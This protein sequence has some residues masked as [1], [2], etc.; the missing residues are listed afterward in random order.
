LCEAMQVPKQAD[1]PLAAIS[2]LGEDMAREAYGYWLL[3]HPVHFVLQR[4]YFSMGPRLSLSE[5]ESHALM[6]VLNQ[7]FADDGLTFLA[8]STPD[9]WYLHV[10]ADPEIST[11]EL[12]LVVGRDTTSYM[13]QG[14]GA[15]KWNRLLNEAQMLLHDHAINVARESRGALA[16]NSVWISGGGVLPAKVNSS[17]KTI[18]AHDALSKGLALLTGQTAKA[19]PSNMQA[20]LDMRH[21]DVVLVLNGFDVAAADAVLRALKQHSLS[22]LSMDFSLHGEVLHLEVKPSDL[23]RFWKKSQS[24][25]STL[26]VGT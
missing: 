20:V 26:G 5:G 19:L 8:A 6:D 2:A 13:P 1:W 24:L 23:W 10:E 3:A 4:D 18:Y 14:K 16:A 7:H 22:H 21:E 15:A 11:T 25:S 9:Y 12:S 17:D